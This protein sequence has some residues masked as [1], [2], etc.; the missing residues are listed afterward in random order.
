MPPD[1]PSHSALDAA[2]AQSFIDGA[3]WPL[4]RPTLTAFVDMGLSDD[5]IA[6]YFAIEPTEVRALRE[7]FGFGR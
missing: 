3:N 1:F 2:L 7:H 5:R 6:A 4:D